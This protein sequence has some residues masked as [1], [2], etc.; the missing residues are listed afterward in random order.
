[1][2]DQEL[3]QGRRVRRRTEESSSQH[4]LS[5][6]EDVR[7]ASLQAD[8]RGGETLRLDVTSHISALFDSASLSDVELV[9][10]RDD[11]LVERRFRCHRVVLASMSSYFRSLFTSGMAEVTQPAVVLHG[12]DPDLFERVLRLLYGQ[13]VGVTQESLMTVVHLAEFYGIAPLLALTSAL[14]NSFVT[15]GANNCCAQL[16]E[17]SALRCA[18]AQ[19]HCRAV[20][21]RDFAAAVRQPAFRKLELATIAELLEDDSLACEEEEVVLQ[22]LSAW[23]TAQEPLPPDAQ[24]AQLLALVR[25]P[26]LPMARLAAVEEDHPLLATSSALPRLLLEGFRYHAA[27]PS[28]KRAMR[29]SHAR[30]RPRAGMLALFPLLPQGGPWRAPAASWK[31]LE[32]TDSITT[33]EPRVPSQFSFVWNVPHFR[34]LSC[35]SM[36]SPAFRVNG[37]S[38]K[39]YLYPKG[40]NA[41]GQHLSVYLDS[42][43]SDAHEMLP[44][45]FRLVC[46]NYKDVG[47]GSGGIRQA[48]D[49]A[50]TGGGRNRGGAGAGGDGSS[51]GGGG[52]A[53]GDGGG[54]DGDG[55]RGDGNDGGEG[56]GGGGGGGG[57]EQVRMPMHVAGCATK[58]ATHHFCKRAKDWGFRDLLP[59]FEQEDPKAPY[60]LNPLGGFLNDGTIS[61]GVF[62]EG[63]P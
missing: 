15:I 62:I 41:S 1:M 29:Q 31:L 57:G 52:G 44:V 21:L 56:D 51:G 49:S 61:L 60:L 26:L 6:V 20:L 54:G 5:D 11:G 17:A 14:L 28:A 35:L 30:C 9:A 27:E 13:P 4:A 19:Q 47:G 55:D 3:D 50:V 38:W 7:V 45:R 43:I 34:T 36:Y 22:G 53:G 42:G 63:L 25:W 32:S 33:D 2:S 37:H 8:L 40:N 10:K 39:L 18:Q 24:L 12:V 46:I 59:L 23:C 16:F 48:S 58:E